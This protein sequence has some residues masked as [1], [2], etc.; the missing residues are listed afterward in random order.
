MC[1]SLLFISYTALYGEDANLSNQKKVSTIPLKT[2]F[3]GKNPI[4]I[5]F[6]NPYGKVFFD[7]EVHTS[8]SCSDCHPPFVFKFD[9][10]MNYSLKAHKRCIGCHESESIDTNCNMC[11]AKPKRKKKVFQANIVKSKSPERQ[12]L[13]EFFYKRRSIRSYLKKPVSRDMIDDLLKAGMAAPTA[14]NCQPWIFIVVDDPSIKAAL[15]ETSPFASYI[16][17]APYVIV[18]A[19]RRDNSWAMF[20]CAV[21]AE[22]MLLAA[23]HMGLG[24]VFCGIDEERWQGA[25][26]ILNVNEDYMGVCYLPIGYP[27]KE[28][29][30]YTKYNPSNIYWNHFEKGRP[31][32]IVISGPGKK[33]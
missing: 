12:K 32:S 5:E 23:T 17:K 11:H 2:Q 3:V 31:E 27:A 29:P 25:K 1:L 19:G 28:K 15:S 33:K 13:L 10:Q 30:G 6:N 14:H 26:K 9:D 22:N 16:K 21:A 18:V 4:I 20:D 7:H 8:F 24:S